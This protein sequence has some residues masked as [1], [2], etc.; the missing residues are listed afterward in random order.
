MIISSELVRVLNEL[1]LFNLE[2]KIS[3]GNTVT[4]F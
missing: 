4:V 1:C 3:E 2:K